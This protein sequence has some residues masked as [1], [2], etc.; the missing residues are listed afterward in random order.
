MSYVFT[1]SEHTQ[2]Q[3]AI[4]AS[5]GLIS[6]GDGSY[7]ASNT[8]G[9]NA[10]PFYQT[11]SDIISAHISSG[12]ISGSDLND[13]K[14]AKLWLDVAIGAN[15]GI[16]IHSAFIRAYTNRQGELRI[17]RI[18]SESEMQEASNAVARNLANNLLNGDIVSG[19]L[20]WNLPRINQ[21]A[22][23]DA[24]AIGQTLF[25]EHLGFDDTSVKFNAAWS[26]ALGF[27]LLGGTSPFE[28]WRLVQSGD[29]T[30][31]SATDL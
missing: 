7:G 22:N 1:S 26:G 27:N 21:I 12:L 28:S 10:V 9:S 15:G 18:F 25:E 2:I 13:L 11:L 19:L 24:S 8:V 14:N 17:N 4:D 31:A 3:A 23:S 16:G 5:T 30:A 29:S 20:P 6:I